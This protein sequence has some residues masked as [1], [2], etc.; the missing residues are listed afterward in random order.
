MT[1][2][3]PSTTA[4]ARTKKVTTAGTQPASSPAQQP[5]KVRLGVPAQ[6]A[7][8]ACGVLTAA[9]ALAHRPA[10]LTGPRV[11]GVDLDLDAVPGADL[12][13]GQ[14]H[15]ILL[16]AADAF[17][18]QG[19]TER[20]RLYPEC[21]AAAAGSSGQEKGDSPRRSTRFASDQRPWRNSRPSGHLVGVAVPP[22]GD[23]VHGDAVD[24]S[25]GGHG[26]GRV[27]DAHLHGGPARREGHAGGADDGWGRE[28]RQGEARRAAAGVLRPA[29]GRPHCP[30][31]GSPCCSPPRRS[32][33]RPAPPSPAR[34]SARTR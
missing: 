7:A 18:L 34:C 17:G 19:A 20:S 10:G 6:V 32:C 4:P 16:L 30:C 3:R 24:A 12:Q 29:G 33:P 9:G 14:N 13:V 21:P 31:R 28:R 27:P 25:Q 26:E 23:V 15:F 11:P 2:T 22:V 5:E 1:A 8:G